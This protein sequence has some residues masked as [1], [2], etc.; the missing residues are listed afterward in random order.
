M[1]VWLLTATLA[2]ADSTDPA[3]LL[4]EARR[5]AVVGDFE[6]TQIVAREALEIE[7]DH[8]DEARYLLGLGLEYAGDPGAAVA[9]YED[10]LAEVDDPVQREHIT[11][12]RAEALGRAGRYE[13]A[14]TQ[15]AELGDPTTRAP[16]DRVK[17][18]LLRGLWELELPS[19]KDE[20]SGLA[21]VQRT[22]ESAAPVDAPQHQA[23]ARA[24]LAELAAA[25]ARQID[26]RG[27]KKKKARRLE[28]RAKLVTL[29][30]DQLVPL[31]R[32]ESPRQTLRTF[33][34]VGR[35]FEAFGQAMLDESRVRGLN[36]AQREIYAAERAD[37]VEAVWVKASRYYDRGIQYAETM[38]WEGPEADALREALSNVIER[39]DALA[40]DPTES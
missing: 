30:S 7:G 20:A 8:E 26:F 14:L 21:R 40:E 19:R 32:L 6:G 29:A 10:L 24:R 3:D 25:E 15:L 37:Q 38:G 5:R 39:V 27:R 12:R 22:L 16:G 28:D 13:D 33:L 4:A 17:M 36:R 35:A 18:E 11:F 31:V 34:E 23:M 2:F 1:I 9:I